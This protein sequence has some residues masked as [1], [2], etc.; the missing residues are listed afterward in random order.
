MKDLGN[1]DAKIVSREDVLAMRFEAVSGPTHDDQP[2][3][4]WNSVTSA[5]AP[6]YGQPTRFD[7]SWENFT[8]SSIN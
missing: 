1:I 3:F 4:E 8:A 7:F 2:V 6:H 5:L